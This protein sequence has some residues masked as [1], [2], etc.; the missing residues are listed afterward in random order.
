MKKTFLRVLLLLLVAGM[1]FPLLSGCRKEEDGGSTKSTDEE[2]TGMYDENGY[3]RDDL[4][5]D[6]DFGGEEVQFLCW[7]DRSMQEF[8]SD[9]VNADKINNVIFE[10]NLR[11]RER[12]GVKLNYTLIP[13][14]YEN[15]ESFTRQVE[16]DFLSG[17]PTYNIYASYGP[18]GPTF[19]ER[20][21][22]ADMK[23][24]SYLNFEKPWWPAN[25][26]SELSIAN[27][28]YFVTGD[29]ST[30][31]LWMMHGTFVNFTLLADKGI[32]EDP[33]ALVNS[34]EWTLDKLMEISKGIYDDKGDGKKTADDV[35]GYTV[36]QNVLE[37]FIIGAGVKAVEK[38]K[39]DLPVISSSYRG[40]KMIGLVDRLGS[41]LNT[42]DDVWMEQGFTNCRQMFEEGR[43][44]FITDKTYI[45]TTGIKD[46]TDKYGLLPMPKYDVEQTGYKT[47][48]GNTHTVYTISNSDM[49]KQNI[50]AAVIECLASESYRRVMP[51]VFD[52][53]LKLRY[54]DNTEASRMYDIMRSGITFDFG[55]VFSFVIGS[56]GCEVYK[57]AIFKNNGGWSATFGQI[58]AKL[59]NSLDQ[60]SRKFGES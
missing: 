35:Y 16:S 36:Y 42:S 52:V 13:G 9:G 38:D 29:I 56:E 6:L 7:S 24:L 8:T 45:V 3:L 2:G 15:N 39:K 58:R 12:L 43:A 18:L 5:N 1:V 20:G 19:A 30:N 23:K 14:N 11:V 10:R 47:D 53:T 46:I 21:F 31:L 60:I 44:L 40:E 49:K 25:I 34:G 37:A 22:S 55:K 4:G 48:I 54:A 27:H 28:L 50:C 41:W 32:E 17:T 57:I 59:K 33:F 26:V 51:E